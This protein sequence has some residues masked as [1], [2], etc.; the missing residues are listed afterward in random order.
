MFLHCDLLIV[1]D[2]A[3]RVNRAGEAAMEMVHTDQNGLQ[4]D[5]ERDIHHCAGQKSAQV[6]ERQ[7]WRENQVHGEEAWGDS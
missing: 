4:L 7:Y 5:V 6:P 1:L 3:E 2:R